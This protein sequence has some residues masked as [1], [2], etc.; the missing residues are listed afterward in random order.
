LVADGMTIAEAGAHMRLSK[1]QVARVWTNV[2]KQL[3]IVDYR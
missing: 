3:G 1:G 2:K